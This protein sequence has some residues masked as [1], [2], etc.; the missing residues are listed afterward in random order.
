MK[1]DSRGLDDITTHIY[2]QHINHSPNYILLPHMNLHYL[3][4]KDWYNWKCV[5]VCERNVAFTNFIGTSV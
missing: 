4:K 2:N 5:C 1:S 3:N